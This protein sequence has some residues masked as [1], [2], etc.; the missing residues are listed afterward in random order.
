MGNDPVGKGFV[1]PQLFSHPFFL[2]IPNHSD[3]PEVHVYCLHK[4]LTFAGAIPQVGDA[5]FLFS[6]PRNG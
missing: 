3:A 1:L 6:L 5:L 4:F 2:S